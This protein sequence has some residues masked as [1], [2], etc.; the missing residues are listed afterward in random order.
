MSLR[1]AL[2]WWV[3]WPENVKNKKVDFSWT[4][5]KRLFLLASDVTIDATT[6]GYY[7]ACAYSQYTSQMLLACS[8]RELRILADIGQKQD[9]HWPLV[10]NSECPTQELSIHIWHL[11]VRM[12]IAQV[13]FGWPL[14]CWPLADQ[15]KPLKISGPVPAPFQDMVNRGQKTVWA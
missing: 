8:L 2:D 13:T 15:R 1:N 14:S 4:W 9:H 3:I 5:F 7:W 11:G 12:R 6:C 10:S